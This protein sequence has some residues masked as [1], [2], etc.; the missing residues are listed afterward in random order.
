MTSSLARLS[1]P[2]AAAA[3][4]RA[5]RRR[6]ERLTGDARALARARSYLFTTILPGIDTTINYIFLSECVFK[7]IGEGFA[8]HRC[9]A[10][11]PRARASPLL[12][13]LGDE[14]E[15]RPP[16]PLPPPLL[17]SSPL[18]E[19]YFTDPSWKWNW[20]DF[21]IVAV[22]MPPLSTAM[23]GG[24][25]IKLLRLLRLA[26]L[27]KLMRKI[28]QLQMIVMGLVSGMTAVVYIL[29]LMFLLFYL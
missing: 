3:A 9:D 22:C 17:L 2:A 25:S 26:R 15:P 18:S 24:G 1:A 13:R 12:S 19:R 11:S 20:F 10:A 16:P 14:A 21:A 29:I 4:A 7:M 8:P 28:P 27:S 5:S 23:G 6:A